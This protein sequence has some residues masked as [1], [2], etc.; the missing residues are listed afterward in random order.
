MIHGRAFLGRLSSRKTFVSERS[1]AESRD[2]RESFF[3]ITVIK[4][5]FV[6]LVRPLERGFTWLITERGRRDRLRGV[7][8]SVFKGGFVR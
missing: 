3:P 6:T 4:R 7:R 5:R 2:L 8:V 1:P